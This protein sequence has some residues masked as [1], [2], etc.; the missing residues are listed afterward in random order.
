MVSR[1]VPFPLRLEKNVVDGRFQRSGFIFFKN[2]PTQNR[3]LL[4]RR[5]VFLVFHQ[6]EGEEGKGKRKPTMSF[7]SLPP[8]AWSVR[9]RHPSPRLGSAAAAGSDGR[10]PRYTQSRRPR[11]AR[12]NSCLKGSP[13]TLPHG[14]WRGCRAGPAPG[15][16]AAGDWQGWGEP[17]PRLPLGL[18]A[19]PRPP[20]NAGARL[21]PPRCAA[22]PLPA[23][24]RAAERSF[25]GEGAAPAGSP[26]PGH[27]W[28]RGARPDPVA[29]TGNA[30]PNLPWASKCCEGAAAQPGLT[31][32]REGDP[33]GRRERSC[34]ASRPLPST[35]DPRHLKPGGMLLPLQF[36]TGYLSQQHQN[37]LIIK[38]MA[39]ET[40][41]ECS[42][43]VGVEPT[44]SFC[45]V[46][47]ALAHLSGTS[48]TALRYYLGLRGSSVINRS[49]FSVN[50]RIREPGET[51]LFTYTVAMNFKA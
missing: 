35:G 16:R 38:R 12:R 20:G 45:Q 14:G 15:R 43:S 39:A 19:P 23:A 41:R 17:S 27:P 8:S 6:R 25:R 9:V 11:P 18:A 13:V 2:L 40:R 44:V 1:T 32:R 26:G 47:P 22:N 3:L 51:P 29:V 33:G 50:R 42:T 28:Q 46:K 24:A 30:A 36:S 5:E 48:L 7:R 31:P 10:A 37:T 49:N 34:P 4:S 21:L